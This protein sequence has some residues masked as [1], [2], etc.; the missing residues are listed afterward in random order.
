MCIHPLTLFS[1]YCTTILSA[2][3]LYVMTCRRLRLTLA[4]QHLSYI[5]ITLISLHSSMSTSLAVS[6]NSQKIIQYTNT[7]C[8][9]LPGSPLE[10]QIRVLYYTARCPHMDFSP[11]GSSSNRPKADPSVPCLFHLRGCFSVC[12]PQ[13]SPLTPSMVT[14]A[15]QLGRS[16]TTV[17]VHVRWT[18]LLFYLPT[19]MDRTCASQLQC[20]TSTSFCPPP[21]PPHLT[22][23]VIQLHAFGQRDQQH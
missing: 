18:D 4:L 3:R 6:K 7:P 17:H 19:H 16:H 22:S 1:R 5:T 8:V 21:P 12:A 2:L 9:F 14:L 23:I 13:V 15:R 11:I 10:P 20:P